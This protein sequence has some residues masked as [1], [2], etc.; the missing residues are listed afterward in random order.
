MPNDKVRMKAVWGSRIR[1]GIAVA[2]LLAAL[3]AL[4]SCGDTVSTGQ[5]PAYLQLVSLEGAKGGGP[6]SG[7]FGTSVASDVVTL[8][9]KKTG[10]PTVFADNGQAT[11]QLLMKD[12][13]LSPS[14]ANAVTITQYHVKYT[15]ADGHNVQGVDVPYE[16]DGALTFTITNSG[17][18][19]FTLVRVQAKQEAP[20]AA[21]VN[22]PGVI[23]T[24]AEV[25][26]YGHDQNGR[27][28]NVS[29]RLTIDF[30]DWGD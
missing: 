13:T 8:V 4:T 14:P 22:N 5:S 17:S 10:T 29:G 24:I 12:S 19:A 26:F 18:L 16:F 23:S 2:G 21:L 11:L 3:L 7:T 25:T 9:P 30:S 20:L 1:G 27:A 28:V 15:R 6:N